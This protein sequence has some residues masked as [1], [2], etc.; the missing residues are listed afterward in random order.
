[1][2]KMNAVVPIERRILAIFHDSGRRLLRQF[3][4]VRKILDDSQEM[5]WPKRKQRQYQKN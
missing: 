5:D 3:G 1:M 4:L 2:R